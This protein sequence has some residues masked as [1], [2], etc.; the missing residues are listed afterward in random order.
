MTHMLVLSDE[1]YPGAGVSFGRIDQ[2]LLPYWESSLNRGMDRG[3]RQGN[4]EM[5][6]DP[7]QYP[8]TTP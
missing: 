6:L 1:N 4:P 5:F 7:C 3:I 2:Y 8:R